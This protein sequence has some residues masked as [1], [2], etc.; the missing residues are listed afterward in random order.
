LIDVSSMPSSSEPPRRYRVRA[1]VPLILAAML[2]LLDSDRCS[3]QRWVDSR[4]IGP[5]TFRA[6][7]PLGSLD[8]FLRQL[9]EL[10][11]ELTRYLGV[12]AAEEPIEVFLFRGKASYSQY[13]KRYLPEVPF[14]RALYVKRDGPGRVYAYWD[15]EVTTDLRHEC[16]HALLHAALPLV[17]LWLDEG[18][19]EY[20]ELPPAQRAFGSDYLPPL[21]LKAMLGIVPSLE[22]LEN[23]GDMGEMGQGEYRDSWAW[24]HFMLHG[25]RTAHL[26]LAAYLA[27]IRAQTPPGQLSRRLHRRLPDVKDRFSAHFRRW[28]Q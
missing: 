13:L 5:F 6:E 28:K 19:A 15:K 14:R 11:E 20:F 22:R 12:P 1:W 21:R 4:Q 8:P 25:S 23:K 3:A 24:V 26:E 2:L 27:D 18:L 17:P 7:F 9:A 16:T 10:Q